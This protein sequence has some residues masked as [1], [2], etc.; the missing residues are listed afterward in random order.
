MT[1]THK[2]FSKLEALLEKEVNAPSSF[3]SLSTR[4][5]RIVVGLV[6]VLVIAI[7]AIAT[8][9]EDLHVYPSLRLAA[10]LSFVALAGGALAWL[11]T[12]PLH[13]PAFSTAKHASLLLLGVVLAT[14]FMALP[15]AHA[16]HPA[17]LL[18]T[19]DDF[20]SRALACFLAGLLWAIPVIAAVFVTARARRLP[21]AGLAFAGAASIITLQLHCPLVS[22]V[23]LLAGHAPVI[24]LLVLGGVL[25]A[26]IGRR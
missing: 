3:R 24:G 26:V 8:P 12:R 4:S 19:G 18:G 7:I 1:D 17:S 15:A 20:L 21:T 10:E 23:H 25:L 6:A 16:E 2:Q 9:R 11:A 14:G 13:R 22:P 5:T